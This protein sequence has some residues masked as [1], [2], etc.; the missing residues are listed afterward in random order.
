MEKNENIRSHFMRATES[1]TVTINEVQDSIPFGIQRP[2]KLKSLRHTTDWGNI[3]LRWQSERTVREKN[4]HLKLPIEV[5]SLGLKTKNRIVLKKEEDSL[6]RK[7]CMFRF[8]NRC[9]PE[10]DTDG[11]NLYREWGSNPRGH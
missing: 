8:N 2:G 4:S 1:F 6:L 3:S 5:I 7:L 11:Q 9:S 10:E